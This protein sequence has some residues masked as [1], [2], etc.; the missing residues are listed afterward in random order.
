MSIK[1]VWFIKKNGISLNQGGKFV[2]F[3]FLPQ[4]NG[5]KYLHFFLYIPIIKKRIVINKYY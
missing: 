2:A 1:G 4:A 5:T 3:T